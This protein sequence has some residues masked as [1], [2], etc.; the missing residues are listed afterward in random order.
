MTKYNNGDEDG[1]D[2]RNEDRNNDDNAASGS[3]SDSPIFDLIM[4]PRSHGGGS[5][6][7]GDVNVAA[8]HYLSTRWSIYLPYKRHSEDVP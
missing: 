3:G 8:T 1:D 2:N 4:T 6:D 7:D 5:G